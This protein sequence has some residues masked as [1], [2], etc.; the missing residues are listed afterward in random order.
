MK[1]KDYK[2]NIKI[3]TRTIDRNLS[4]VHFPNI[5]YK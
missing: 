5:N 1:E 2:S 4:K 3:S